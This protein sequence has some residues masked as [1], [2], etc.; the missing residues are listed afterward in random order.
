MPSK[1]YDEPQFDP[2]Y[3]TLLSGLLAFRTFADT[4]NTLDRL[5]ELRQRFLAAGDKKGVD[6][7]IRLGILGR[8]RAELIARNPRVSSAKRLL[9]EEVALWFRIWLETP[10]LFSDW[11][12]LR[13]KTGEFDRLR[14]LESR[15]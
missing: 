4:E 8:R 7:C 1:R 5:E 10:G 2:P 3:D 14:E 12:A 9:K 13:K 11:L 6:C 15:L